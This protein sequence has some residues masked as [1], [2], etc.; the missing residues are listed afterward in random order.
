MRR[1][2]GLSALAAI[3]LALLTG[4]G[5]GSST[6]QLGAAPDPRGPVLA[7]LHQHAIAASAIGADQIAVVGG[8]A[9]PRIRFVA[10][11]SVAETMELQAQAEGAE[12]IGSAL[13]Y[14]NGGS[15]R[16]LQT[17]EDCLMGAS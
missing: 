14:V 15:D 17:L 4:C 5:A 3:G 1:V 7:C 13:L 10:A 9:A 16:Q 12:R 8:P 6:A 2:G 11:P